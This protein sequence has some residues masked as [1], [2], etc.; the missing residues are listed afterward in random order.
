MGAAAALCLALLAAAPA[1]GEEAKS[2]ALYSTVDH[3]GRVELDVSSTKARVPSVTFEHWRHRALYT[4]RVCHVDLGFAM[5][6]GETQ[7]SAAS[8]EAGQHCGACHDG[9]R[10]HEG[11]P[12]FKACAG[13]P[14]ADPT[15]GCTRCHTGASRGADPAYEAFKASMPLDVAGYVD[16]A[17]AMRRGLVKPVD[18]V[19]GI[20]PKRA[21]LRVDRDVQIR[22]LG[23]W[24]NGVTFSHRKHVAWISCELCHPDVFPMSRRDSVRYEMASM[25]SGRA[26]GACHLTVAFPLGTCSRCH[27]VEDGRAVR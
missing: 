15:R 26:C 5:K 1:E 8:N 22:P 23:T 24:M 10:L 12:I 27:G 19:E 7:V 16:W 3:H 2:T 20:S 4:C 17:A 14:R 6:A 18:A 21:P 11:R 13:W 9:K 25:R